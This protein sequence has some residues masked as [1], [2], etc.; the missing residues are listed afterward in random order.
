MCPQVQHSSGPHSKHH[1]RFS[2]R[3][4]CWPPGIV[5]KS[6]CK[7]HKP[8]YRMIKWCSGYFG[9]SV[10]T[11][12]WNLTGDLLQIA[13]EPGPLV[14]VPLTLQ[15]CSTAAL[16]RC[17]GGLVGCGVT[18]PAADLKLVPLPSRHS[19][20]IALYG[21]MVLL[22]YHHHSIRDTNITMHYDMRER[23]LIY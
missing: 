23:V 15:H 1:W 6:S 7:M 10:K 20:C 12:W 13:Q 5:R 9:S 18:H 19:Q 22:S 16:A 11:T 17:Q 3:I 14:R 8:I 21:A 4:K 2:C